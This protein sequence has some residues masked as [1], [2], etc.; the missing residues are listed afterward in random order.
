MLTLH[1]NLLSRVTQN[2]FWLQSFTQ[3][4][5]QG[6][7]KYGW[8]R[9]N[10]VWRWLFRGTSER[11]LIFAMILLCYFW[12]EKRFLMWPC[13]HPLSNYIECVPKDVWYLWYVLILYLLFVFHIIYLLAAYIL[14]CRPLT[15]HS[16]AAETGWNQI[17]WNSRVL[18]EATTVDPTHVDH[19]RTTGQR[20]VQWNGPR[21]SET[22]SASL[23]R[24]QSTEP[25]F[26]GGLRL[27]RR[28]L[29]LRLCLTVMVALATK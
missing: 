26:F 7:R 20:H 9:Y 28:R 15:T 25:P 4:P 24:R 23:N 8:Y 22:R 13:S 2:L 21:R 16:P 10:K 3:P 27:S 5:A 18:L 6:C 1:N 19:S 17:H 11:H 29:I 14:S 12:E